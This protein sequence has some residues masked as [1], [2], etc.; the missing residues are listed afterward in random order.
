MW[1]YSKTQ[2]WQFKSNR[3][4]TD[5]MKKKKIKILFV[6]NREIIFFLHN[7]KILIVTNQ[8][9]IFWKKFKPEILIRPRKIIVIEL[10][11]SNVDQTEN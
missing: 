8:N 3:D 6:F 9:L 10:T 1:P 5:N 11:R 2:I 4:K 7:S